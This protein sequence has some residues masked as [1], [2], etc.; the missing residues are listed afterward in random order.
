MNPAEI[1]A[2]FRR[3]ERVTVFCWYYPAGHARP[4]LMEHDVPPMYDREI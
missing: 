1:S 4:D 2:M 3:G